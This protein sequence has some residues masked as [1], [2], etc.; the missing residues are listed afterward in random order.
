MFNLGLKPYSD[1]MYF[2]YEDAE[3]PIKLWSLG[4]VTLAYKC[5]LHV[6]IGGTG[7]SKP[8]C[9]V[10]TEYLDRPLALMVNIPLL[11]LIPSLIIRFIY[12]LTSS[13]YKREFQ[14]MIRAYI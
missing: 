5:I 13:I 14:Y 8:L 7:R 2:H 1:F 6:H 11:L 3:F 12:D 4:F 10:Y 9:R